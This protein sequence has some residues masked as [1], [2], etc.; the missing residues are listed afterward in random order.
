MTEPGLKTLL[1]DLA[2]EAPPGRS[3][4]T[5]PLREQIR[6]RRARRTATTGA[7]VLSA[8]AVVF[9]G[10]GLVMQWIN[11]PAAEDR[12]RKFVIGECGERV[13]DAGELTGPL[14][15]STGFPAEVRLPD[16]GLLEGTVTFT[17]VSDTPVDGIRG[18]YPATY[19]VKDGIVVTDAVPSRSVGI[20][21]N[22]QPGEQDTVKA[23]VSLQRCPSTESIP[24]HERAADLEPGTYE[25]YA[26]ETY[27][28]E[29]HQSRADFIHV[30]GGP[31]EITL[32]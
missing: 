16:T 3:I 17:N 29:G 31:W 22:L 9:G 8:V 2:A 32:R 10:A 5:E 6:R 1:D 11:Q 15:M 23:Y 4:R 24:W 7:A 13:R 28:P 18:M 25:I 26:Q 20:S 30:Y 27:I 19:L 21:M 12:Q 14:R